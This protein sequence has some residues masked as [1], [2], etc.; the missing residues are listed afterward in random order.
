MKY[1]LVGLLISILINVSSQSFLSK[2][3]YCLEESIQFEHN[4]DFDSYNWDFC[5]DDF[6]GQKTESFVTSISGSV[7]P[8]R[9]VILNQEGDWFGFLTSRNSNNLIRLDFGSDILN[10]NP[11]ITNLGRLEGNILN[12][13]D[14]L[15][16]T[17]EEG[18]W[19]GFVA[20]SRDPTYQIIR[21][22]FGDNLTNTP[23]AES[24]GDFGI[25]NEP[26]GLSLIEENGIK[27]LSVAN[28][29]NS[30]IVFLDFGSSY[31]TMLADL[32][33][34]E[35]IVPNSVTVEDA[36]FK[37][38]GE[39]WFAF[40][41][42][43]DDKII[44]MHFEDGPTSS[45]DSTSTFSHVELKNPFDLDIITEGAFNYLAIGNSADE[46]I[47]LLDL[48]QIFDL[49]TPISTIA[50]PTIPAT[51][52]ATVESN[53]RHFMFL[54]DINADLTR[55]EI[56]EVCEVNQIVSALEFPGVVTYNQAGTYR[57]GLTHN[58][59]LGFPETIFDTITVSS[60]TAPTISFTKDISVCSTSPNTFTS[61]TPDLTYSWD[62][63]D[64]G[65]EDSNL[66]NPEV[67]FDTLG[68]PGTY[69]V[70]LDVNDGTCDNFTEQTITIYPEPP[71][72][73]FDLTFPSLCEQVEF[74]LMN[75]IDETRYDDVLS[76][77]WFL[78]GEVISTQR[79]TVYTFDTPGEKIIGLQA[80]L[81]GCRPIIFSPG[82]S[83]V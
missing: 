10:S 73:T 79:D 11:T 56:G 59:V 61:S 42:S 60:N 6:N 15:V 33:V 76:Y 54:V 57:I 45:I 64:D 21:I 46:N 13:P 4:F 78:N 39:D 62:F 20:R 22:T 69:V 71:T 29:Q 70:R 47:L 38:I 77:Q 12:R 3:A 50:M 34:S 17:R 74:S 26:K 37:K 36:V 68:G 67:L 63:D 83:K 52:N 81:P 66:P 16:I 65:L 28:R 19:I 72:P 82:V 55:V 27:L 18:E 7:G 40:S 53:G 32:T 14:G 2:D 23:S 5:F 25:L 41:A 43:F 31:S 8:Q 80:M 1:L 75:T 35:T 48:K 30:S 49:R 51:A 58:N 24:L 9:I 44:M